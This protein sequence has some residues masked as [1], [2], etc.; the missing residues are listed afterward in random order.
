VRAARF[1]A[2][3]ETE[4]SVYLR[5]PV[6][7]AMPHL[8][9][10]L[11]FFVPLTFL[12]IW[13]LTSLFNRE[14]QQLPPRV[15]RPQPPTG[16]GQG[17]SSATV[18]PESLKRDPTLRWASPTA[19]DRPAQRRPVGRPD[20]EI[21]I[22]EETRRPLG[23]AATRPGAGATSRRGS[24]NRPAPAPSPKRT[25]PSSL[26]PLSGAYGSSQPMNRQLELN[27]LAM[28]YSPL[29]VKAPSDLA[30]AVSE[31]TVEAVRPVP[32]W[33]DFRLLLNSPSKLREAIVVSEILQPPLALRRRKGS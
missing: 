28:P 13:A 27:P 21:L 1:A 31:A 10:L 26:R 19:G 7:T 22:I 8:D 2:P 16:P 15:G 33:D 17:V 30:K 11:Q 24:R 29:M 12:A 6:D 23:Q 20:E 14:A 9:N 3:G 5:G 25:E 4:V 32:V 18:R